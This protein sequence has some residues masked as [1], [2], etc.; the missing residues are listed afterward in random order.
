MTITRYAPFNSLACWP[1]DVGRLFGNGLHAVNEDFAAGEYNWKPAID[2][3]EITN[4]YLIRADLPG[5]QRDDVEITVNDNV[6]TIRGKRNLGDSGDDAKV[7]RSERI[8]GN[9]YRKLKLPTTINRD[10]ISAKYEN[11]VLEILLPK[12]TDA[13][14]RRISVAG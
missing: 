14:P 6:L 1:R 12:G 3:R 5:V 11:G 9:Y 13:Q 4:G 2:V 8:G 7:L 10:E